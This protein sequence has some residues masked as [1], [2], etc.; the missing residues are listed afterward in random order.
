MSST[1]SPTVNTVK[2]YKQ[3]AMSN[4]DI[5]M[6]KDQ[7]DSEKPSGRRV[8]KQPFVLSSENIINSTVHEHI[9]GR[10]NKQHIEEKW[11][12]NGNFSMRCINVEDIK[13]SIY[14]NDAN[15][16]DLLLSTT[17][18]DDLPTIELLNLQETRNYQTCVDSTSERMRTKYKDSREDIDTLSAPDSDSDSDFISSICIDDYNL[19]NVNIDH[20]YTKETIL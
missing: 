20:I 12:S 11:E 6:K 14:M 2:T 9:I 18:I 3:K 13:H 16:Y 15:I 4:E 1:D 7:P 8:R 19:G 5:L 10:L 17:C